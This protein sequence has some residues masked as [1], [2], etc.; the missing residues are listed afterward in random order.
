MGT[1]LGGKSVQREVYRKNARDDKCNASPQSRRDAQR[2]AG[3]PKEQP[4]MNANERIRAEI[5][6][7]P[8]FLLF[9]SAS[10]CAP[11]RLCGEAFS[12]FLKTLKTEV[13]ARYN[14]RWCALAVYANFR[15]RLW[16]CERSS[17]SGGP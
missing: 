12:F 6:I 10:L 3:K 7:N 9:F 11:L 8:R 14:M 1:A 15:F 4:R 17:I 16:K 13:T 2:D 5:R